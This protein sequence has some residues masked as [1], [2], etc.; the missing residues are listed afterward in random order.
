M[1]KIGGST[2]SVFG[3]DSD[4]GE[5]CCGHAA[6]APYAACSRGQR[7][8]P[9]GSS[10]GRLESPVAHKSK[11]RRSAASSS[12]NEPP[13]KRPIANL[14]CGLGRTHDL[15]VVGSSPADAPTNRGSL[16]PRLRDADTLRASRLCQRYSSKV[17]QRATLRRY[18]GSPRASLTFS[19]P[20]G[21]IL[22]R[23]SGRSGVA[24]KR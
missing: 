20:L 23:G 11:K 18:V 16:Q 1:V 2:V 4:D 19:T 15:S 6:R 9:I 7:R 12:V 24:L 8:S 13:T 21:D 17:R 22:A 10:T 14:P 3:A 5:V